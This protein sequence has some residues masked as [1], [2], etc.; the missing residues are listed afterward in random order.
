MD[1]NRYSIITW[2]APY[3]TR[4]PNYWKDRKTFSY[5]LQDEKN[6]K[7]P[8]EELSLIN[9]RSAALNSLMFYENKTKWLIIQHPSVE[10]I[11]KNLYFPTKKR[12]WL[13][14]SDGVDWAN[15][16][17]KFSV[18][19]FALMIAKLRTPPFD[20]ALDDAEA[21]N[22]FLEYVKYR[23]R[24]QSLKLKRPIWRLKNI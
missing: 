9:S 21:L 23:Y 1:K 24:Y 19:N 6:V 3:L 4:K 7:Y 5:L 8:C 10:L 22:K 12:I 15:H 16:P 20:V 13:I 2:W 14:Y 11:E 17:V 18:K